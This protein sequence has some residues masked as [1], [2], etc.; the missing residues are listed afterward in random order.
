MMEYGPLGDELYFSW[1]SIYPRLKC[2]APSIPG[3]DHRPFPPFPPGS[4]EAAASGTITL[5]R[6]LETLL[7][8]FALCGARHSAS[9]VLIVYWR[10]C[11]VSGVH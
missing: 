4:P 6:F 5:P 10:V 2:L 3:E 7:V 1:L 11:V 8:S 9:G